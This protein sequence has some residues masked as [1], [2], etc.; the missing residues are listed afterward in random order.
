M[1]LGLEAF[2]QTQDGSIYVEVFTFFLPGIDHFWAFN[3][4]LNM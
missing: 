3:A 1:D 2:T 4:F